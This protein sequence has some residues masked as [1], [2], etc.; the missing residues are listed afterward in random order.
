MA[1]Q[2]VRQET[3]KW[4]EWAAPRPLRHEKE[5]DKKHIYGRTKESEGRKEGR[6]EESG[7]R[8]IAESH[9]IPPTT[10]MAEFPPALLWLQ[11]R[12]GV[13]WL[14]FAGGKSQDVCPASQYFPTSILRFT[15]DHLRKRCRMILFLNMLHED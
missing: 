3:E 8:P 13:L 10:T 5:L 7:G 1:G 15:T 9:Y 6:K 4:A 11:L 14:G 2:Y 12:G